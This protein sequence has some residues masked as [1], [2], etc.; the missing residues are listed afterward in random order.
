LNRRQRS[1]ALLGLLGLVGGLMVAADPPRAQAAGAT[2]GE[3]W[4]ASWTASPTDAATPLDA[5]GLAVPAAVT[6][7]TFRM[8]V[9]PHLG[10]GVLRIHLSNRF[11]SAPMTFGHVTVGIAGS[12]SV[13]KP[14]NVTFGGQSGVTAPAGR[15]VVS[16]P[17]DLT[18]QAFEPLAVSIFT[19]GLQGAPTKHWNANAT[20]YY[21]VP[22]SG[23]LASAGSD[24]GFP[25]VTEAWMFADGIDVEAPQPTGV[26]VAFGDSITDGF[27]ASTAASLPVS[28]SAADKNARYPD[29]LQRRIDAAGIPLSVVDAGI[30]SNRLLTDGAGQFPGPSGLS[31]FQTDALGQPGVTGVLVLEGINDLGIPPA[32]TTAD[33]LIA[34]YQQLIA[35]AHAAGVKIWLGT[36]MP[37]SNALF[38]GTL[39]APQ[40]ETYREQVNAWIRSQQL[41]DGVVDFDAAMR[42]PSDPNVLDPAYA[43][44]DNLHPDL[45]GYQ[46]MANTVDLSMLGG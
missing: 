28:L 34:G 23:D 36:I 39:L 6:D 40:S 27:V 1:A 19:P 2:M 37:A 10:G 38:D 42:D 18:F 12:G 11:G 31:R 46:V 24:L 20:S 33:Q 3:Q 25:F 13:Q 21:S 16:D 29:D 15:D 41:A 32:T 7:Q 45:L 17:V 4:A 8:I 26:V 35:E 22:L 44:V 30:S 9:T 14:V 5:A 43:G